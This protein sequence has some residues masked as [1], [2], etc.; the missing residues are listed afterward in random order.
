MRAWKTVV[1]ITQWYPASAMPAE[2]EL[3]AWLLA[4]FRGGLSVLND[5]LSTYALAS[6]SLSHGPLSLVDLPAAVPTVMEGRD[7]PD[8]DVVYGHR[9]LALHDRLPAPQL[10]G[11]VDAAGL[12][13][14][15]L[16]MDPGDGP[17][18][19]PL[20]VLYGAQ[21]HLASGRERQ[22]V[23]DSGTGTEMLISA[24]L[25]AVAEARATFDVGAALRSP[26]RDRFER[27]LP[28]A[29]GDGNSPEEDLNNARAS[30]WSE[31]YLL[32]NRVVHEGEHAEPDPASA[33]VAAA[34]N[35][36]DACGQLLRRAPDTASLGDLLRVVW[37]TND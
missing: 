15:T 4:E 5:W 24:L 29:L 9:M 10:Q 6:A 2:P 20:Q 27:Q 35:L 12:A 22:A 7:Q 13:A 30:W 21:V 32:C 25:R 33:A 3:D 8:D 34:W 23:L 36:V 26:F 31:G 18:L 14:R 17:F 28:I 37:H 11:D 19:G 1:R 16:L